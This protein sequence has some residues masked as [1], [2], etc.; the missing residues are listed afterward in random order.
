MAPESEHPSLAVAVV[1]ICSADHLAR[2]LEA[3]RAQKGVS[4]FQII[5]RHDPALTG[6][7]AVARR[8]PEAQISSSPNERS[9]LDL[10]SASLRT[11]NADVVLLTEDHCV[12][13]PDWMRS[14]LSARHSG[15]AV[16]GGRV[17]IG[18]GASAVDWA[19]Y[20]VDFFRYSA[21]VSE[22]ASPTLTV[23]NVLYDRKQLEAIRPL[24]AVRFEEPA[25]HSDL[26]E[27]FGELWLTAA[28]RVVMRRHVS[29]VDALKERYA[30][31]RIFG[32]TRIAHVS[33]GR[34]CLFVLTA[35][36][37]PILL[38]ARMTTK[39]LK[40]PSLTRNFLRALLP[41]TAMVL[42]WSWGEW[43]GYLTGQPPRRL[44][45]AQERSTAETLVRRE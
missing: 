42:C 19:F 9:P 2:C 37:L 3:L 14:M 13:D 32:H 39:A 35:P 41:L 7:D 10:A 24:W 31:G 45:L 6:I 4:T 15:R 25:V 1:C 20:Y 40:S 36:A 38:L 5:V 21:P 16:V 30:F 29:F 18:P 33:V 27:R 44:E 22:G 11:C 34:R 26:R 23:C 17:E 8:Y 43:L 12:P 28:S